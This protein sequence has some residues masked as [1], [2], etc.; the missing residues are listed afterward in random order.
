MS[1][2]D[3]LLARIGER[4]NVAV[5]HALFQL[6][7]LGQILVDFEQCLGVRKLHELRQRRIEVVDVLTESTPCLPEPHN[8]R[9]RE[10]RRELGSDSKRVGNPLELTDVPDHLARRVLRVDF[11]GFQRDLGEV[12]FRPFANLAINAG[13]FAVEGINGFLK[14]VDGSCG[15]AAVEAL[16]LGGNLVD[17]VFELLHTL[18]FARQQRNSERT[19]FLRKLLLQHSPVPGPSSRSRAP[20]CPPQGSDR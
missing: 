2:S 13:K 6:F 7:E 10:L 3:R 5:L 4:R 20:A 12:A 16:H 8:I 1:A 11:L 19:D 14:M 15:A 18:L 17:G 9:V